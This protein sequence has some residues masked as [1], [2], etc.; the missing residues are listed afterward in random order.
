[1]IQNLVLKKLNARK[2]VAYDIMNLNKVKV[3]K[4]QKK[5]YVQEKRTKYDLVSSLFMINI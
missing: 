2:Q 5:L 3:R 4:D 1:M